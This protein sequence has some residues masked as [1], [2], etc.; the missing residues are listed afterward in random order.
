MIKYLLGSIVVL[1]LVL[2]VYGGLTGRDRRA[3]RGPA[4]RGWRLWCRLAQPC[5]GLSGSADAHSGHHG[6]SRVRN[7]V[8]RPA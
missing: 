2:L 8:L 6:L 3:R 5:A 4:D 7:D 1:F